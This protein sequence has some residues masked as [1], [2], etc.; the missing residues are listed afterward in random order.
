MF[1]QRHIAQF[2]NGTASR[3]VHQFGEG[4]GQA[5]CAHVVDGD[6]RVALAELPAAVDDFL[7][8]PFDFGVAALHGVEVQIRAVAA[9]VHR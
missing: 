9:R 4:V 7:R 8:A 1:F 5:A 2:K 6:N 3:V